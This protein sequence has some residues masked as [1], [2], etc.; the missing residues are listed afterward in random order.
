MAG[1]FPVGRLLLLALAG[2]PQ[3]QNDDWVVVD[4]ASSPAEAGDAPN[5]PDAPD[6]VVEVGSDAG[7]A[8]VRDG[9]PVDAPSYGEAAQDGVADGMPPSADAPIAESGPL[10]S[11]AQDGP[12]AVQTLYC[13]LTDP[14]GVTLANGKVCWVGD[15]NPRG[16][17]CAPVAGGGS[18]VHIDVQSDAPLLLD[19]FD[20][21]F[22]A[23]HVYWTN[24][25]NN[26]V[27]SR[28]LSGGQPQQYFS[29][30]GRVSF[31]APGEGATLWAT[32][33]PDPSDP[34]ATASGEV[35]VGPMDGG[36]SS[37]A[38]YNGQAGAAGVA[39]YNGNV[40]WG[41]PDGLAFGSVTGTATIYR[42]TSPETPVAGVAVDSTGVV[43]FLAGNQS[44]YRYVTGATSAARVF[45]ETQAF[46]A[47]DVALDAQYV[48]F[49][50]PDIGCIV[51][52]AR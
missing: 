48:Y 50:E 26:Q 30:G 27:V 52:I 41:A 47:G 22:D 28:S 19:A 11:T 7:D 51:R 5:A 9:P 16:L 46:G 33:F 21:V 32:D 17:F 3:F 14:R 23:T 40:Y 25:R 34:G 38:I 45:K 37:N 44:L 29:G 24:G 12:A 4:D 20:L 36:T 42:I 2:C 13:G 10:D 49:S 6:T 1:R 18:P 43:Y 39:E 8:T 15:L 31:L 35:V